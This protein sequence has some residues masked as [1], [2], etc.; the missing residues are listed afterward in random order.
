MK[1]TQQFMKDKNN[2]LRRTQTAIY[3]GQKHQFMKEKNSDF[4]QKKYGN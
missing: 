1:A 2:N 3:D 4:I